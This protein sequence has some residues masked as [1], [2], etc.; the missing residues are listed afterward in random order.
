MIEPF[1]LAHM[2]GMITLLS[3]IQFGAPFVLLESFD[4][5]M[6]LDTIE[7]HRCTW[8]I[9]FPAQYAALLE[10]QRVR[11]RNLESLRICLTGADVCPIDLQERVTS[12]FGAP[13]YSV[14]GATEVVGSLTFA[15]NPGRSCGSRKAPLSDLSTKMA[16]MSPKTR[17]E[18]C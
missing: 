14:W 11:P 8:C 6:V 12:T 2:S 9:G 15:C 17:S 18:S 4:A 5:D 16:P 13:L 10:C 7:R 1:P 3:F